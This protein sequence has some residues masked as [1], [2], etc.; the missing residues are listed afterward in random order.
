[1]DGHKRKFPYHSEVG[2]IHVKRPGFAPDRNVGR[3]AAEPRIYQQ[4][5]PY[6]SA[7]PE[8]VSA[9]C[10]AA[11]AHAASLPRLCIHALEGGWGGAGRQA[12]CA[13]SACLRMQDDP[14]ADM[15]ACACGGNGV[16]APSPGQ[17][18][19]WTLGAR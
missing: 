7:G 12:Q 1:M 10:T 19:L 8:P 3:E 2:S 15:R 13:G 9:P 4:P 16:F 18:G 6:S 5:A 17:H 14:H 11:H